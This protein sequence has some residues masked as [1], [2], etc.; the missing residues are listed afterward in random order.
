MSKIKNPELYRARFTCQI[1]KDAI[2]GKVFS[3]DNTTRTDYAIYNLLC[4]VEEIARYLE[5]KDAE[6]GR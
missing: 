5:R 3:P 2:D 6:A 1:G 4:A